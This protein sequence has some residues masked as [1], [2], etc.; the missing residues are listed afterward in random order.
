M[1]KPEALKDLTRLR[2]RIPGVARVDDLYKPYAEAL[3]YIK[4]L[5]THVQP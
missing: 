4:E 1:Y 5:A 2:A 3:E